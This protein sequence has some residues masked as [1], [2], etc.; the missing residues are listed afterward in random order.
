MRKR[1]AGL[2]FAV[3]L[4]LAVAPMLAS[5]PTI[6]YL[7]FSGGA[8][9]LTGVCPFAVYEEPTGNKEKVATFYNQAGEI[10]VQIITGENKW[11]FTNLS[12]GKVLDL[13]ASGPGRLFVQP[14]TDLVR[15][16]TGGVSFFFIPNPPPGMPTFSLTRGRVVAELDPTTFIVT[17]LVAQQ[18]TVQDI[19]A[20]LQ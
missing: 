17:N 1:L 14:G 20:L 13:N 3:V 11:R 16:V 6:E 4:T 8:F 18:G 10:T 7:D 15:A 2:V 12:T 5:R 19:C 9:T